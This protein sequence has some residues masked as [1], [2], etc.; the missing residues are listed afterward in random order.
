MPGYSE[1]LGDKVWELEVFV[2]TSLSPQLTVTTFQARLVFVFI[3]H[4]E[5]K[6]SA[7][8]N[9]VGYKKS[10]QQPLVCIAVNI[11]SQH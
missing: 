3:N 9:F 10:L 11:L 1:L 4:N 6:S 5:G 2:T 8:W 7:Q